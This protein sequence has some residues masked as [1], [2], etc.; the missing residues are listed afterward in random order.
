MISFNQK[1]LQA[2][3]PEVATEPESSNRTTEKSNY[4]SFTDN[5]RFSEFEIAYDDIY[6]SSIDKRISKKTKENIKLDAAKIILQIEEAIS[7]G[8]L[9]NSSRTKKLKLKLLGSVERKKL[10]REKII[11]YD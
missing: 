7:S 8:R 1:Y 5:L 3:S 9:N 4:A 6:N 2:Q 11:L 10:E